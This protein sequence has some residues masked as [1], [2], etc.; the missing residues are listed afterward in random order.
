[1]KIKSN[2]IRC[3]LCGQTI[4]SKHR[5]DMVTCYCGAVSV[6]G[7]TSYL[8]RGWAPQRFKDHIPDEQLDAGTISNPDLK[9]NG[10]FFDELSEWEEE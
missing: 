7:G 10:I 1:M 6:D 4:E 2:K 3:K 9:P 5:H 8:K